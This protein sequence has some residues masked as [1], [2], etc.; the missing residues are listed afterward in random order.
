MYQILKKKLYLRN[1]QRLLS[2]TKIT[3]MLCSRAKPY[4]VFVMVP[5]PT[6]IKKT[7]YLGFVSKINSKTIKALNLKQRSKIAYIN[8]VLTT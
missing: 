8:R 7:I 1:Y 6:N 3:A 5:S 4:Q 2:E